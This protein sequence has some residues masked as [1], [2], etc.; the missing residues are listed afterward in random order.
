MK[1]APWTQ[2]MKDRLADGPC[3]VAEL[4]AIGAAFVPPGYALRFALGYRDRQRTRNQVTRPEADLSPSEYVRIG[5]VAVVRNVVNSQVR[6]G[7]WLRS[8]R[9][10]SI[11]VAK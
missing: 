7:R 2:A 9:M 1:R 10:V 5:S 8:G 6:K 4:I 11:E 3:D